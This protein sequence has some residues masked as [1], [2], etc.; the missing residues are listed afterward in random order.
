M[1]GGHKA[2]TVHK[3]LPLVLLHLQYPVQQDSRRQLLLFFQITTEK[4]VSP[5]V[6][7]SVGSFLSFWLQAVLYLFKRRTGPTEV[8]LPAHHATSLFPIWSLFSLT[9]PIKAY[10][11]LLPSISLV[12]VCTHFPGNSLQGLA[13]INLPMLFY[14]C[15]SL[16]LQNRA[17]FLL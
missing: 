9:R 3:A 1:H 4:A 10:F 8:S 5:S 14:L 13:R 16:G 2:D 11:R 7:S 6:S 17:S 15:L 12:P